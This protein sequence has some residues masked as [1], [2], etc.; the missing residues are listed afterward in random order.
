MSVAE[1]LYDVVLASGVQQSESAM[2]SEESKSVS[3]SVVSN[4]LRP[5]G[6]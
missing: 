3:C 1:L 2:K 6:L 4:S 5:R